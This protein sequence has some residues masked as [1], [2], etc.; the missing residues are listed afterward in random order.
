MNSFDLA[1]E[2]EYKHCLWLIPSLM[3]TW[4]GDSQYHSFLIELQ[5]FYNTLIQFLASPRIF[6]TPFAFIYLYIH[7]QIL[8]LSNYNR[9]KKNEH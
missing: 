3:S 4:R 2:P 8:L 5:G 9:M 6:I 7:L 1:T